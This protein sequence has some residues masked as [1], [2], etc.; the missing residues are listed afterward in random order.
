MILFP[1]LQDIELQQ[2][3][4]LAPNKLVNLLERSF[5]NLSEKKKT[6]Y[7]NELN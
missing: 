5:P 4:F 3:L 1:I 6:D 2:L 7:V